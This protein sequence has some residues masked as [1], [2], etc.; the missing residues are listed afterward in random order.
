MRTLFY[1]APAEDVDSVLSDGISTDVRGTIRLFVDEAAANAIARDVLGTDHYA[2]FR[3]SPKG[4]TAQLRSDRTVGLTRRCQRVIRQR[5][6]EPRHVR[7]LGVFHTVR[8]RATD[9]D[10]REGA[11][12]GLSRRSVDGIY[13][14]RE[15]AR[16]QCRLGELTE[17]Q[18]VAELTRLFAAA[19][20]GEADEI[21]ALPSA[22]R[23]ARRRRGRASSSNAPST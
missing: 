20:E 17:D 5:H 22:G 23:S 15:W 14:A 10:Y 6:V 21:A 18:I 8:D 4:I 2:V 16:E 11:R 7:L 19:V 9:W 3:V 13:K 12:I 1:V